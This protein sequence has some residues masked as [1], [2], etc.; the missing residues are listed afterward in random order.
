VAQSESYE[1]ARHGVLGRRGIVSEGVAFPRHVKLVG[2]CHVSGCGSLN[3]KFLSALGH[4]GEAGKARRRTSR[5]PANQEGLCDMHRQWK[6]RRGIIAALTIVALLCAGCQPPRLPDLASD[7]LSTARRFED[8]D[9]LRVAVEPYTEKTLLQEYFGVDLLAY[10]ILPVLVVVENQGDQ[11]VLVQQ[12]DFRIHAASSPQDTPSLGTAEEARRPTEKERESVVQAANIGTVGLALVAILAV[13]AA[14]LILF[15]LAPILERYNRKRVEV[16]AN[17]NR[18]ALLDKVVYQGEDHHGFLYLKLEGPLTPPVEIPL[19]AKFQ[20]LGTK[21]DF[22]FQ[23]S[24]R[25]DDEDLR[26]RI[27]IEKRDKNAQ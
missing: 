9:H 26:E 2:F 19:A 13:P 12:S 11:A 22:S 3:R 7:R 14:V 1:S 6:R 24:I 5:L 18:K 17:L 27:K 15:P 23:F 16:A 25:L 4:T 20:A 8:K 21:Q 10:A